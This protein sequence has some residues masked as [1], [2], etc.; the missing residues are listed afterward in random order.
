MFESEVVTPPKLWKEL[1][2]KNSATY[3]VSNPPFLPVPAHDPTISSR[4]GLFSSGG[5][6]GEEFF[7]SLIRLASDLLD[8]HD[9]SATLAV[10]S[11]FMNPNDEDFDIRL[12]SWWNKDEEIPAHA[13]LLTNEEAIDAIEYSQRRADNPEEVDKWEQHLQR[14]GIN[15]ISPGL[16]FMKRNSINYGGARK[17]QDND[18]KIKV[19]NDTGIVDLTH[20]FVPKTSGGSIW[21]PTNIDARNFTRQYIEHFSLCD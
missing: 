10:V 2:G 20:C 3:I 4:Y 17:H 12:T 13:L 19:R 18:K 14:E 11:E 6:T 8:R 1:L 7:Q 16:L 15:S 21:T 5:S 9:T